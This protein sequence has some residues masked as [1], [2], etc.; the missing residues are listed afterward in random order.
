MTS[1]VSSV[2]LPSGT[3][4]PTRA[5]L[6]LLLY[7]PTEDDDRALEDAMGSL[8]VRDDLNGGDQEAALKDLLSSVGELEDVDPNEVWLDGTKGQLFASASS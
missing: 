6:T 8:S 5:R 7:A 1:T 4:F 2:S 3:L